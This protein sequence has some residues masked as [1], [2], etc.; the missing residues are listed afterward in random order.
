MDGRLGADV[1][2]GEAKLVFVD[3]VNGDFFTEDFA[4]KSRIGFGADVGESHRILNCEC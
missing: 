2:E 1:A 4:E 3:D